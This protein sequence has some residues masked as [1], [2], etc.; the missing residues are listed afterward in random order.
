MTAVRIRTAFLSLIAAGIV[1]SLML[2]LGTS[3]YNT[4]RQN[5]LVQ[6]DDGWTI[7]RGS[8]IETTDDLPDFSLGVANKGDVITLSRTLPDVDISPATIAFKSILSSVEVYLDQ[9]LIYSYGEEY[10]TKGQMLPKMENFVQLPDDYQGKELTIKITAHEDNAFGG[11]SPVTL[12]I[13]NDI[14]NNMVQTRRVPLVVGVYLCHLGFMLMIMAPF[15]AFSKYSDYS[16]FF[17]ALSSLFMGIYILCF[18]DSFWYLSDNPAFYTHVEYFSLFMLPAVVLGFILVAGYSPFR[19]TGTILMIINLIFGLGTSILHLLNL[20]HIC[21]FVSWL[22]VIGLIEGVFVIVSLCISVY[23]STK[24]T[25]T[26]G[27]RITSTQTL[28]TGLIVF[29][30]CALIDIVNFNIKKFASSGEVNENITFMTFG[31]LVFIMCLLLNY[32][33]HCIEYINESTS[34]IQLEGLAYNDALTGISNRS[35]CEQFLAELSGTYTII[36]LDLDHLKYTNDNYGHAQ[37]DKLISGFSDILQNSFTD[38]SLIGR[39]GGDEFIVVLPFIDEERTKRDLDGFVDLM[40]IKNS[41]GSKL[42]FSASWGY[43]S[44]KEKELKSNPS[45]QKVYLLADQRMYVM[46]NQHHKQS[47]GRLYNDLMD[48]LLD[49]GGAA[50]E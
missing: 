50:D 22:H 17:S 13:Y 8:N 2:L 6:L 47:L 45:A 12:G 3:K 49:K 7:S 11:F 28:I 21:H 15:L 36:S 37:G 38:A 41:S 27:T 4:P 33:Y 5:D 40:N 14:K 23:K 43:A 29:L 25:N 1:V 24:E 34:K 42:R 44:S 16:I 39:M 20:V 30:V 31:A 9:E 46:K 32:F 18:N 26:T 35:K 10:V 48:K 19:T